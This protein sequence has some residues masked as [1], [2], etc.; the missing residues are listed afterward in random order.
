MVINENNTY[1]NSFTKGMNSDGAYDQ[2]QNTQ[3][4]YATNVRV[5]KNQT[6]GEN[7]N[8]SRHEGV[9]APVLKGV[10]P[11]T[12]STDLLRFGNII[13]V[14]TVDNICTIVTS[15]DNT[16]HVY[17]VDIN[18]AANTAKWIKHIWSHTFENELP[19]QIS[20]VL[21]KELENVVKLYIANG[22]TPIIT[23]RVDDDTD[24]YETR[25]VRYL[26]NCGITPQNRV[27]INDVLS[28]HLPAGQIQYTYRFYNKY[29][30]TTQLAPLTNKIQV[31]DNSRDREEGN[32][33]GSNTSLGFQLYIDVEDYDTTFER[34]QVFRLAYIHPH[35]DAEVSLI[36]DGKIKK[37]VGNNFV[38]ND[39]GIEPLQS[40]TMEE[41]ASLSGLI[42]IPQVIENNQNYMF[43]GNITDDTIIRNVQLQQTPSITLAQAN[44]LLSE[45]CFGTI[46]V[47]PTKQFGETTGYYCKVWGQLQTCTKLSD[48]SISFELPDSNTTI[49]VPIESY[50]A[51]R[52][53]NPNL[54]K[55][56]YNNIFTSSL[57]RSL[58][59]GETYK[60]GVV[61]YD[62]KGRRS[63]V[64]SIG[65]APVPPIDYTDVLTAP[66]VPIRQQS[67]GNP[68]LFARP[69]GVAISVPQPKGKNGILTDIE[70]CQIVRRS[71]SDIYQNTLLQVALARPVQQGLS[72]VNT[73]DAA[74]D[75]TDDKSPYYPSGF[76]TVNDIT[77][78]PHIYSKWIDYVNDPF[79]I[80]SIL[81][82]PWVIANSERFC[83]FTRNYKLFQAF[84]SEINFRRDDIIEK[85]SQSG[86]R[87]KEQ[88]YVP[89]RHRM[90]GTL[91]KGDTAEMNEG[92]DFFGGCLT[93]ERNVDNSVIYNEDHEEIRPFN[94]LNRIFFNRFA[95]YK[96]SQ[97]EKADV[98][99]VFNYFMPD[100]LP[101]QRTSNGVDECK[102]VDVKS[103]KDVVMASWN[104]GF[105]NIVRDQENNDIFD[106]IKKYKSFTTSIDKYLFN[107][108]VSF[109]KY[110]L[111]VG[112]ASAPNQ[113]PGSGDAHVAAEFVG[114]QSSYR[115]WLTGEGDNDNRRIRNGYIGAG[116]SSFLLVTKDNLSKFVHNKTSD[117]LYTSICNITHPTKQENIEGEEYTQYFGFGNYFR[118]KYNQST[119][120]YVTLND[121]DTLVVFD[122]DIY[123]TPQE[124]TTEYKTYNFESVDTLQSTQITNYVPLESKVNTYFDYGMNLL[125]TNNSSLMFEPGQVEGIVTQERPA[126]QYNMIYSAND[127]SNDVF[128]RITTDE[129][130]TNNFKQRAYFSEPKT[131]GEFIDNYLIFKAASFIDVD[132]KYGQITEM[133][134]DK[135]MLYYWQEHAFGKFSV[136]ERSLVND[137][138]GNTI[139][140]GQAGILSRYDYIS[141]QFG[142]RLYD[143]CAT[144]TESGIYW[145]DINN[146]AVVGGSG[147]QAVNYGEHVG[148][149]NILNQKLTT[150]IPKVDYDLQNNELIC[151]CLN[152][153]TEQLIFNVKFNMATSVYNREYVDIANIKNHLY[154]I[155]KRFDFTKINYIG[156]NS[157]SAYLQPMTVEFVVN[158]AASVTKVFDNQCIIPI[159]RSAW[160]ST[161]FA[162]T[163]MSF[164]TDLYDKMKYKMVDAYNDREGNITFA[165][166]RF[167][168]NNYGNRMRGKWMA[169]GVNVAKPTNYTTISHVLTKYRQSFS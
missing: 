116:G 148:V 122:G 125:N 90:Y 165:I 48:S 24:D 18:E 32:A 134:S 50:F 82:E 76:L 74:T 53:V 43:C 12:E 84:S 137:T 55:S 71:S 139:M 26:T 34:M 61:F 167:G 25:D 162:E 104:D 142:M 86:L 52:G 161:K 15:Q 123:I 54:P 77:I 145:V 118:L 79:N 94:S 38:L 168:N 45:D 73:D 143:F 106:G 124:F 64:I 130:E 113:D 8:A 2:I 14:D 87:I 6:L 128:T 169:V 60:Y 103:V 101:V 110:D 152:R 49:E 127:E 21:Y 154:T 151:K 46:P 58:R 99:W 51:E 20:T 72:T 144:P 96:L 11:G 17:R 159:D 91:T 27:Y 166:P 10:V 59:R 16:I 146:K 19:G 83:A 121:S 126:H 36:Y 131:N 157:N 115:E 109:C 35:Q 111:N 66:F 9:V 68:M 22:S 7:Q 69:I 44:V 47:P 97:S 92:L 141:T 93:A 33:E 67:G 147:N 42:L 140:L 164:K 138:N 75:I 153:G 28:G 30:N 107:N 29:C 117:Q 62:K 135:N 1:T 57:L 95:A 132:S 114:L 98:K 31:I 4:T 150:E 156:S 133:L 119:G 129:K 149:Q 158:P 5:A 40:L 81:S 70:G 41:F 80:T 102:A 100:Q 105:T 120:R 56:T 37:T 65:D 85:L 88:L 23:L 78:Y 112:T 39:V 13:A 108:W 3:Y 63:D 163:E 89:E 160:N 136:N 155:S